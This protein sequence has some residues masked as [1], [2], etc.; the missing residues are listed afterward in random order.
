MHYF[1]PWEDS[2]GA[3]KKYLE[4]KDDLH[5]GRTPR[6]GTGPGALTVK[7][8][9]NAFLNAKR[10][11]MEAG[12][13]SPRTWAK[14]KEVADLLVSELGKRR[15]V[16]D[17][18]P[19]DF[20][21]LKKSMAKRW[22]PLRVADI[23]QHVRSVFK[24]AVDADLIDRP[25]RFGPGFV[26]PSA[27]VLRLHRAAQGPKLFTAEDVRRLIAAADVQ[28]RAHILLAINC[29]F[30]NADCATLPLSAVDLDAA[31]INFPRP[32]TGIP[33][34]CPLWPETVA[35]LREA[36]AKRPK[37]RGG[38]DA[39]LAFLS[40]RGTPLCSVREENRTDGVAVQF[41]KL[42]RTLKINGRKGIGFYTL[43]HTFRTVADGAKDQP[44]AD[45][46][47]GH[48]VAHMSSV[49]REGIDDARLKAV[50]DHVRAWL[51]PPLAEQAAAPPEQSSPPVA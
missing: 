14:Y 37:P 28:A 41:G 9:A 26:R 33:R 38:A 44:D 50:A 31:T 8:V 6:P 12:E 40:L 15:L 7:D 43:R 1:G 23:I 13:L 10:D 30:G 48:E 24:H 4:Q 3:L 27:K 21:A 20:A 18:R 35:A 34:R 49:Y 29:G 11:K 17:L 36:L 32:K 22:G 39:P 42:L 45:F 25:V 46:I 2:D 51:F 16:S 5:A 47:M 19:D